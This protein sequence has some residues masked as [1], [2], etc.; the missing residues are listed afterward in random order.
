MKVE[1]MASNNI[2][3]R[4]DVKHEKNKTELCGTPQVK[5]REVDLPPLTLTKELRSDRYNLNHSNVI[6]LRL[7]LVESL[8]K[9]T[10]IV[11]SIKRCRQVKYD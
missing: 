9:R 5:L 11:V 3:N 8:L 6:T 10:V 2:A 1:S 7:N 4:Q